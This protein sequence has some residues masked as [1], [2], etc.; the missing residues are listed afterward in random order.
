MAFSQMVDKA[1]AMLFA[2]GRKKEDEF[3]ADEGGSLLLAN[4]GYDGIAL[5]RYLG[6]VK[7]DKT[8]DKQ[9]LSKTHPS[10]EDRLQRLQLLISEYGLDRT[11]GGRALERFKLNI[12][13][14]SQGR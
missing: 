5:S 1:V 3:E 10:F 13:V 6:K 8:S 4:A 14:L 9:I 11:G 12:A 7:D 2:E